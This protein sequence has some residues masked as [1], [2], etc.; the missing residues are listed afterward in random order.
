V[1]D[2]VDVV[3]GLRAQGV[4]L[5]AAELLLADGLALVRRTASLPAPLPQEHPRSWC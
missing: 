4:P 2:A 1:G 3:L 5:R